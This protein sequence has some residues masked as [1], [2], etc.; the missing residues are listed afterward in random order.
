MFFDV[1]LLT[2]IDKLIKLSIIWIV[3]NTDMN[4]KNKPKDRTP[5]S[6]KLPLEYKLQI[7]ANLIVDRI[8]E[9]QKN[10]IVRISKADKG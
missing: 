8:L 3:I 10:G 5:E 4:R 9:D 1:F 6:I 7:F 2:L